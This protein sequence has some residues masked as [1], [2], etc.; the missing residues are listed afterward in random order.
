MS[1]IKPR[2]LQ[3]FYD[4]LRAR[5][6]T[7]RQLAELTERTRPTITRVINGTRRRGPAWKRLVK[8]LTPEEVA[9]LDVAHRSPWNTQRI[10]KRPTW[11]PACFNQ[12]KEA[13]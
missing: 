1:G 3:K 5:G 2:E 10:A 13:A 8:Y 7:L 11:P 12:P 9:L 4:S 6:V